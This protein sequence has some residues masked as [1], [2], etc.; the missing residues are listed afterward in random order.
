MIE[1]FVLVGVRSVVVKVV[2]PY[3]TVGGGRVVYEMVVI[4]VQIVS[5]SVAAVKVVVVLTGEESVLVME[6]ASGARPTRM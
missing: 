5:V 2:V 1:S 6:G 4:A 3:L